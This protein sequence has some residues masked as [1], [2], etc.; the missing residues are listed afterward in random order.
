MMLISP[1]VPFSWSVIGALLVLFCPSS[2]S[3][4]SLASA[5]SIAPPQ[6]HTTEWDHRPNYFCAHGKV[7]TKDYGPG[8]PLPMGKAI[9]FESDLFEG[10]IF[11]RLRDVDSHPDDKNHATYFKSGKQLYQFIIQGRF[12]EELAMSDILNG[13]SYDKPLNVGNNIMTKMYQKVMRTF[14]PGIIMEMSAEKPR[15]MTAFGT[16]PAQLMM[17]SRPGEEPDITKIG[18]IQ[19]ETTLLLGVEDL[20]AKKRMS[21]LSKPKNSLKHKVRRDHIYTVEF[22]DTTTNFATYHQYITGAKVDM[23]PMLNGQPLSFGM[24]TRDGR[25]VYKFPMWHERA[26]EASYE[27]ASK[28]VNGA[29]VSEL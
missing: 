20:P 9:E 2:C 27:K 16:N 12:K 17:V 24:F 1:I 13:D 4:P 28:E 5:H 18:S 29:A 11:C 22:H 14:S 23:V 21:Y 7:R 25:L 19:E 10:R 3:R 8:E 15:I 26:L 6:Q